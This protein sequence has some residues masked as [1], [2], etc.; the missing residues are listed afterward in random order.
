MMLD[1][2]FDNLRQELHELRPG[3]RDRSAAL[4]LARDGAGDSSSADRRAADGAAA[5]RQAATRAALGTL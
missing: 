1:V 2:N 4:V 5:C 3:R